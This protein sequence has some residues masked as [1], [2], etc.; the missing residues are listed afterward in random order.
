MQIIKQPGIFDAVI[1]GSGATGGWMAKQL[2]EAGMN[3][4]LLEAGPPTTKSEFTEHVQSY[5]L[6]YRWA[7]R[8]IA[9]NRPIQSM[10]YAC[11]ESNYKWFVDDIKNPYTTPVDKPYQWTRGR[12]LGGRTLTWG[13][14][15]YRYSPMDLAPASHDGFGEDWPVTYEDL[16][17]Y[18]EQVERYVGISGSAEGLAQLPDSIMQ[19]PMLMN[20][21]EKHF[22]Q[23]V[24]QRLNRRVIMG[25]VAVL[26]EDLN[27]RYAC[28]YCGPCEQGCVTLSY[29]SSPWTTIEDAVNTGRCTVI[30]DAV[31]SHV[32][33]D[34]DTGLAQGVTYI[35]RS[36]RQSRQIRA[37]TVQLCASTLESTRILL[38]SGE[39]FCN[40]SGTL[41]RYLM[42]HLSA[43]MSG[44]LPIKE[45]HKWTGAP[46]RPTGI[47]IPRFLNINQSNEDGLLRG[48]GYQGRHSANY[49]SAS[50]I[51]ARPGFGA[52]YKRSI[53]SSDD[54]Y[55]MRLSSFCECLPRWENHVVLDPEVKD[56]WGIPALRI[57]ASWSDNEM[58][59]WRHSMEQGQEM[60]RAAGA[61]D[62]SVSTTEPHWP[63]GKTHEVGTARMGRD[64]RKS[65]LNEWCQT[66]EVKNLFVTDGAAFVSVACQNPTLTMMALTVRTADHIVERARRGE[67]A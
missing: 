58:K 23:R 47:Y 57:S 32:D 49:G 59:L 19:P 46:Q 18:Y 28:H 21:G 50:A 43:G 16:K 11:R 41:G 60:L 25:R 34:P 36:T 53:Q 61:E 17:P 55:R 20:C 67:L 1:V 48:Y 42:D 10:K 40:S 38:N 6:R 2:A 45:Q 65:V 54:W 22:Q 37:K 7:S 63:G 35:D 8:E 39:G 27:G 29:F 62:I 31:V 44:V 56:A 13:R 66:H 26:T 4:A 9:R 64:P 30:T 14:Q 12:Q 3:V 33:T 52:D 24:E 15:S 51:A 5:D